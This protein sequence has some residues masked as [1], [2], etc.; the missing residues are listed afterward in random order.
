MDMRENI[1][2]FFR[3]FAAN[4]GMS[5]AKL[6]IIVDV[7]R[8]TFYAYVRGEGNPTLSSIECIAKSLGVDPIAILLGV[9]DPGSS[10][11]SVLLLNTIRGMSELTPE[12]RKQFMRHFIREMVRLWDME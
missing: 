1:A 3:K 12:N 10:E 8:N 2:T 6:Q 4:Q 5:I 9:Y 11:V 7:S